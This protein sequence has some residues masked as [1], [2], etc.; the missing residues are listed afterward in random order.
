M[1][2]DDVSSD[3]GSINVAQ[4]S[5][6]V[7]KMWPAQKRSGLER[8][9][10][11]SRQHSAGS[12]GAATHIPEKALRVDVG[13]GETSGVLERIDDVPGLVLEVI[14]SLCGSETGGTSSDD[15]HL[16]LLWGGGHVVCEKKG[17]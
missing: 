11:S 17:L 15:E 1:R 16:N 10:S 8:G 6:S 2:E 5:R 3:L 7:R 4:G 12:P 13:R 9:W 14:E